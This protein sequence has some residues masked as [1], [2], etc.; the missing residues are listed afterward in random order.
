MF[1]SMINKAETIAIGGHVRP[2]G[3]CVGSCLG[4]YNYLTDCYPNKKIAVYLEEI[5]ERFLFLKGTDK[6]IHDDDG[7]I[8]YDLFVAL[9]CGDTDRLGFSKAVLERCDKKICID[10]HVSN[11]GYADWD[12]IRPN[13]SST[14]ELVYGFLEDDKIN[15][16]IAE[17]LYLGIVH[18][19]GVFQYSNTAPETMVAAANLMRKGINAS[20]IIE[21]TFYE[22]TYAQN[23]IL[24]ESLLN[25]KLILDGACVVSCLTKEDMN[26]YGV[27][28]SDLE[29]IASQL[30]MTKGIELAVFVY[31]L[32]DGECKVS[33]RSNDKVDVSIIA[34]TFGGGGHKKAAGLTMKG[35]MEEIVARLAEKIELQL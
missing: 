18:D 17:C 32:E 20:W 28:P 24:G 26:R 16:E 14:S 33:M 3:D 34:Q 5:P 10:H 27:R 25:A 13:A 7:C 21:K 2:D 29:G 8:S 19:T 9:D 12:Y 23:K 30:R 15:K 22:K 4:L 6:I 11:S 31:E 35:R 1:S